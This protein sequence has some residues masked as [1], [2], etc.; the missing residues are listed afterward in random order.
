MK[1]TLLAVR[2]A[3]FTALLL[4]VSQAMAQAKS[5]NDFVTAAIKGDNSEIKLGQLA[6]QK[7]TD[8]RVRQFGQTLVTDHSKAKAEASAVANGLSVTPPTDVMPE[9]QSE[10][11]KLQGLSGASFDKEFV[12]YMIKDHKKDIGDFQQERHANQ[13]EASQLAQKQLPTLEKHL[14]I[15]ESLQNL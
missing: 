12:R 11:N 2:A 7:G 1:A 14:S 8:Q 9:A 15:A 6:A 4:G 10:Y 13:G 3:A 5:P